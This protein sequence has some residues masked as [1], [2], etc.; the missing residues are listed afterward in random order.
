MNPWL[1]CIK[2]KTEHEHLTDTERFNILGSLLEG[3]S[4]ALYNRHLYLPDKTL[5]LARVWRSLKLTYGYRKNNPMTEIYERSMRPSVESNS[6]GLRSLHKDLIFCLGRIESN[7]AATLI[8]PALVNNFVK[9]LPYNFRKQYIQRAL[10]HDT[11]RNF[12]DLMT[13]LACSLRTVER[14]PDDWVD[15]IDPLK[16]C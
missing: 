9:R 16:K 10:D 5:A 1:P 13:Y 6:K 8:N 3:E 14:D 11:F 2:K 7:I 15:T 4:E 12:S